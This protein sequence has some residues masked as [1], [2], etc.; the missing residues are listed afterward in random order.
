MTGAFFSKDIYIERRKGLVKQLQKGIVLL[1]GNEESSMN[2]KDNW[3]RFRQ[4]SSFLYYGGLD[5]AGLCMLID[6]DNDKEYLIGE[7]AS[8]DDIIWTGPLPTIEELADSVGIGNSVNY[9]RF[10]QILQSAITKKQTIQIL[11][12]YR[13][14]NRI[15]LANWFSVDLHAVD[16]FVSV[17]LIK[18]IVSQREIKQEI[19]LDE[20]EKAV[21][22]SAGMHES[23]IRGAKP[24]MKEY[25]LVAHTESVANA[26]WGR[27]AYSTILTINGQTLHNHYYGN[28]IKEGDMVLVDAGA[29]IDSH[30]AG[31]L[32][33]TFPV[34]KKFSQQQKEVYDIVLRSLDRATSLLAPGIQYREVHA[35]ASL[36]LLIGLKEIGIV[37]GDPQEALANDVHTLFFQCGLGHMIG[38]DVHDME[39]LGEQYVGYGDDLIKSKS[40]GW[41]S[42]RLAKSLKPGFTI[43]VEPGI[44]MIPELIDRRKAEKQFL[45]FVNYDRL[46]NYKNFG[47]IRIE[48]NYVV[49]TEGARKLGR[50]LERTAGEMESMR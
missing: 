21:T 3:Y 5:I 41:K 46:E 25:E 37:K 20:M 36:E 30:Y 44:Y 16:Q 14:E 18:T 31:D 27:L 4:D 7:D 34:A 50:H 43:T 23:V 24:G 28:T 13:P 22:V 11:P 8:I 17:D 49:T 42:L 39:D 40:F 19:E 29:E 47:G 48:D 33:R 10:Q 26:H 15:K 35:Q 1:L 12:P 32:T 45:D 38:L 2:Y 9:K 6:I